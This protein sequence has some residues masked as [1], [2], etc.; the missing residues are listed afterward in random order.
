MPLDFGAV[1]H[2]EF[3]DDGIRILLD[4]ED[5]GFGDGYGVEPPD[6][7]AHTSHSRAIGVSVLPRGASKKGGR[8][9]PQNMTRIMRFLLLWLSR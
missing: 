3:G 8:V 6:I 1:A 5:D 9:P 7:G 4:T 2:V